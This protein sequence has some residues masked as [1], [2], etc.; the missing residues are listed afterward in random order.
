MTLRDLFLWLTGAFW[1]GIGYY[2]VRC[3]HVA[4]P[5]SAVGGVNPNSSAYRPLPLVSRDE[6]ARHN[7]PN[8]CWIVIQGVVFDLTPYLP[9][10][11]GRK[12]EIDGYCG[13]DGTH[14]WSAKESGPEKGESHTD[15]AFQ[16]L[17]E[18]PRVGIVRH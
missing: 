1:L 11:P 9:E 6:V 12:R 16:I 10:H 5:V 8:D 7:R 4:P 14:S 18:Y 2:I 3:P 13:R 15:Q 17:A